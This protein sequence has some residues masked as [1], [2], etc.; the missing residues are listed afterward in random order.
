VNELLSEIILLLVVE[1]NYLLDSGVFYFQSCLYPIKYLHPR[2]MYTLPCKGVQRGST[3]SVG[4]RGAIPPVGGSGGKR[5]FR[6]EALEGKFFLVN[7]Y[8]NF[9]VNLDRS[10]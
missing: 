7:V 2:S 10:L 9:I 6:G 1:P 4:S 5:G 3:H 8:C